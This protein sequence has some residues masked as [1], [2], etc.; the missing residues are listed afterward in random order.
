MS[1]QFHRLAAAKSSGTG[2]TNSN[3]TGTSGTTGTPGATGTTGTGSMGTNTPSDRSSASMPDSTRSGYNAD[4]TRA[5]RA[6]RN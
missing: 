4:G 2:S 1:K 3:S 6:D 5:A